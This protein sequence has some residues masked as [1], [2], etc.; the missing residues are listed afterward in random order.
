MNEHTH[1]DKSDRALDNFASSRLEER[2]DARQKGLKLVS[3]NVVMVVVHKARQ[4]EDCGAL[5][6][7]P[8]APKASNHHAE[9]PTSRTFCK[10][11]KKT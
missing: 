7:R 11:K 1:L 3:W 8:C 2:S 10:K 4:S 5:H 6:V 9:V